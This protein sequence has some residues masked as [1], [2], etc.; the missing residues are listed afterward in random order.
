M[1]LHWTR[2]ALKTSIF[3]LNRYMNITIW[4][5][6]LCVNSSMNFITAVCA[7][8][9]WQEHS[10]PVDWTE[11]TFLV[12]LVTYC[13]S[14]YL[15]WKKKKKKKKDR[16]KQFLQTSINGNSHDIS[17]TKLA[18][19]LPCRTGPQIWKQAKSL[20]TPCASRQCSPTGQVVHHCTPRSSLRVAPFCKQA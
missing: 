19:S 8:I 5:K 18:M 15:T 14:I 20:L 11:D 17:L 9:E 2:V 1:F 10:W 3:D 6:T 12:E 7:Q 13:H 16:E 4:K